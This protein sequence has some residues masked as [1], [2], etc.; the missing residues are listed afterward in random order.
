MIASA[1]S[2][3]AESGIDDLPEDEEL[4]RA[5]DPGRLEQVVRDRR[6]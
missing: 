3:G 1:A 6:A 5:V 2:A 4:A